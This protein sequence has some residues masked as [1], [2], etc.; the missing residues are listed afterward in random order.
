VIDRERRGFAELSAAL[1]KEIQRYGNVPWQG[2]VV[3]EADGAA[4]N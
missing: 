3:E 4:Q 2:T 1:R